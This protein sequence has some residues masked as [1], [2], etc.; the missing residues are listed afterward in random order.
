MSDDALR[1]RHL[2]WI[3]GAAALGFLSSFVFAD[4][5]RFQASP[6]AHACLQVAAVAHNSASDLFLPPHASGTV[7]DAPAAKP[8]PDPPVIELPLRGEW[9][10]L[11]PPGHPREAF[12]FV[13]LSATGRR[14]FSRSWVAYLLSAG[15][16]ADSYGWSRPVYAPFEGT[17]TAASDGWPDRETVNLIRDLLRP[18]V[19]PPKV[20]DRDIRPFAGNYVII[21]SDRAAVFLAHL[22]RGSVR[23]SVGQRVAP[24]QRIGEVGNSG[25]SLAPHLHLQLMDGPDPLRARL[26][27]FRLR[28]YERW[29]GR[30]WEA[31]REGP[32]APGER[33]RS[34]P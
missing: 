1:R 32:L 21:Q 25:N 16:A 15:P 24:G 13:A 18:L 34:V 28:R 26:V 33:I 14:Y 30:A 6:L 22:R 17:V 23:A 11:R 31:V 10:A 9:H 19:R 4:L 2:L 27:P 7:P 3:A 20:V 29:N 8:E 5:L 12:D